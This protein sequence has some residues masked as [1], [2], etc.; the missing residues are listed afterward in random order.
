MPT[1]IELK[2]AYSCRRWTG[3]Q[4]HRL[5]Q[6]RREA[7]WSCVLNVI[8]LLLSSRATQVQRAQVRAT[9]SA[10]SF[11][12]GGDLGTTRHKFSTKN[13]R[14]RA[15]RQVM[16]SQRG[17]VLKATKPYS[18]TTHTDP[19]PHRHCHRTSP[20]LISPVLIA[21]HFTLTSLTPKC[22]EAFRRLRVL[23]ALRACVCLSVRPSAV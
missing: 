8:S 10:L 15:N 20:H 12:V 23:A 16:G 9:K 6:L 4:H 22:T 14:P 19:I 1:W 7:Y 11:G 13:K 2:R 5:E 17:E 3:H 21:L 18:H